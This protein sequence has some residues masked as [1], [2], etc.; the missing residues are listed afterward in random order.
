MLGNIVKCWLEKHYMNAV[1]LPI[2]IERFGMGK[3]GDLEN[4]EVVTA[5]TRRPW[6]QL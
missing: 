2:T 5:M 4:E 3:L 6:N 1:N